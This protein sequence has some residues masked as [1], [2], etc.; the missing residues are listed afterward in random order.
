MGERYY[1]D[2]YENDCC[3]LVC[4]NTW[5]LDGTVGEGLGG[6]A[7]EEL[8]HWAQALTFQKPTP[9]SVISLCFMLL[10][11]MQALIY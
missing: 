3:R 10:D 8:C 1:H 9:F 11:Q 7:L 6:V 4:L 2:L 5:L